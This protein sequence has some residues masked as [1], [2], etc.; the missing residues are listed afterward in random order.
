MFMWKEFKDFII[1]SPDFDIIELAV[2]I[3]R[4]KMIPL[5]EEIYEIL[6]RY[7]YEKELFDEA[8]TEFEYL[9]M[10]QLAI[11]SELSFI[12]HEILNKKEL[13]E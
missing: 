12:R 9:A 1:S 4:V 13:L 2:G 3:M 11:S 8:R 5:S 6:I 10:D 7:Y